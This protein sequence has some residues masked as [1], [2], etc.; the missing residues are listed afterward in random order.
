M[1]NSTAA[2][3]A[4]TRF[5]AAFDRLAANVEQVIKG[6]DGVVRLALLCVFAEGHLLIEDRPGVGKTMLARAIAASVGG[7]CHRVQ[8]TPD[9]LPSDVLGVSIYDQG[10]KRFE[11]REGPVFANVVLADE[12]NRAS[13]KTQSALL[14]VM[15]ERQVTV[16]GDPRDVPRPFLVIATQNPIELEGTYRLP[17]AQLDR[18]LIKTSVGYPDPVAEVQVM[19]DQAAEHTPIEGL[20]PVVGSQELRA[21]IAEVQA[22]HASDQCLGY[23][24]SI[25]DATRRNADLRLGVSPRASIGLLRTARVLAASMGRDYVTPDDVQDLAE[26]VLG[27]RVILTPEA[28]LKGRTGGQVVREVMATVKPIE[29]T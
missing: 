29:G 23:I 4:A 2:S 18:F 21:L 22:T 14:E 11:Y 17:E 8:F 26:P 12:I 7:T 13:P 9:L 15:E 25:A 1:S 6:K 20:T 10:A 19:R 16:E 27:H 5:A 24:A 3:T 28:E